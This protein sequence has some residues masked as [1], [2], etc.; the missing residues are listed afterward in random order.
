MPDHEKLEGFTLDKD[1]FCPMC[2]RRGV[3]VEDG[4]GDYYTGK[5]YKCF[6]CSTG[7]SLPFVHE[8]SPVAGGDKHKDSGGAV[9]AFKKHLKINNILSGLINET[10]KT[11][12]YF[13]EIFNARR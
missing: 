5:E 13:L 6:T 8:L 7:F 10:L 1:I 12:P 4:Q 3:Y 2:G 11:K 9:C